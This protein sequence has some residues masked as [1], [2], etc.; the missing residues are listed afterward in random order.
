[1]AR[2]QGADATSVHERDGKLLEADLGACAHDL[3]EIGRQF[4]EC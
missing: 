3:V 1:M 2:P 4:A